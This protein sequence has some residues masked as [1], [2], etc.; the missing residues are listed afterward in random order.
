MP[1]ITS[2]HLQQLTYL[3]ISYK[4]ALDCIVSVEIASLFGVLSLTSSL[5]TNRRGQGSIK[6]RRWI[7][8]GFWSFFCRRFSQE[9]WHPCDRRFI[10]T[11]SEQMKLTSIHHLVRAELRMLDWKSHCFSEW[12]LSRSVEEPETK[13]SQGE[14]CKDLQQQQG[15]CSVQNNCSFF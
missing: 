6:L 1:L 4:F 5:I 8:E 11:L 9:I 13:R 10:N 2:S 14:T 3:Q 7:L 12:L 15:G